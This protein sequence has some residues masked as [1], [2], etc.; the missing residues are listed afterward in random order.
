VFCVGV[1]RLLVNVSARTWRDPDR[2][3]GEGLSGEEDDEIMQL[4]V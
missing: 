4:P 2:D 3:E 1:P